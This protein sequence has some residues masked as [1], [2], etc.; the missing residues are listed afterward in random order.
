MPIVFVKHHS[1]H[2]TLSE[3]LQVARVVS[4]RRYDATFG[5][6]EDSR[7]GVFHVE[8][9]YNAPAEFETLHGEYI[10]GEFINPDD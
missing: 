4:L 5:V 3:A 1:K 9:D 2:S 8:E 6:I 7:D 10:Q